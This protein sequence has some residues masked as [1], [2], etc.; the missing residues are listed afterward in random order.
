MVAAELE[1]RQVAEEEM[2][3]K[4]ADIAKEVGK[5][6]TLEKAVSKLEEDKA[7][8]SSKVA[9]LGKVV[10]QHTTTLDHDLVPKVNKLEKEVAMKNQNTDT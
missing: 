9:A 2:V 1:R 10:T 5:V 7:N 3:H 8:I 4:F 6:A